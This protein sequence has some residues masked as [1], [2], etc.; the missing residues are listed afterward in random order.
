MSILKTLLRWTLGERPPTWSGRIALEGLHDTITIRREAHGVP[1]IDARHE[2]DAWVGLGFCHAQDRAF[3]LELLLRS[4]RGTLSEVIGQEGLPIDRL[5]RR[6]GFLRTG[7]EQLEVAD[8]QTQRQLEAYARGVS[9]GL[10]KG[11][12]K[13][14]PEFVL[15]GSQP[16]AWQAEDVQGLIVLLCF[17]LASNWDVELARLKILQEDGPDALQSLDPSYLDALPVCTPPGAP[18]H[19]V[20]D[21]LSEDLNAFQALHGVSGGSN[22]WAIA[23]ERTCTGGPILAADPHLPPTAP[24]PVYLARIRT[25]TFQ[26]V[27]M[28]FVGIPSMGWG[29]NLH[30]AWGI[31][32]AHADNTDLF[33]ERVGSDGRSVLQDTHYQPCPTRREVISVKGADD[34]VEEVLI[35]PRGPL[36]GA[37]FEGCPDGISISGTWLAKRPYNGILGI[38]RARTPEEAKAFFE[39][40]SASSVNLVYASA[41][42]HVGW[43][44][45]VEIPVRRQG[46]G[47]LPTPGWGPDAG[48]EDTVISPS[49]LPG[50]EDP[51]AG[52]VASANNKPVADDACPHF[53]GTDWLDGYR[54]ARICEVLAQKDDW[55][56]DTT[57]ALQI[58]VLSVPWRQV[59]ARVLALNAHTPDATLALTQLARWDGHLKPESVGASIFVLFM[60][61]MSARVVNAK[62]PRAAAWAMG[63]GFN[64]LLPHNLLITRRTSHLVKL[65]TETPERRDYFEGGWDQEMLNALSA[66]V[67][68][69]KDTHGRDVETWQWGQVR[70]L[71]LLH[72]FGEKRPLDRVFNSPP[73][74]FG[75]DATTVLQGALELRHPTKNPVGVPAGRIVVD[76]KNWERSRFVILGGQSGN[77]LSKHYLDQVEPWQQGDGFE[78]DLRTQAVLA[79]TCHTLELVEEK[80]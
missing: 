54:Q 71:R 5:S 57:M 40:G 13:R 80:A 51:P 3:Q 12:R 59:R 69:L 23:K 63:Q 48:W 32:A 4:V 43:Q 41:D 34:I 2:D 6:V 67:S 77:P 24:G 38:H 17:A 65:M 66:V 36:I 31:T 53:L 50:V 37:A 52:F 11:S 42:G 75:S 46:S 79:S 78:L 27:G 26:T 33:L 9:Q 76:L 25:P 14:A 62:A 64:A 35:T 39:A 74:A 29:H 55:D 16:S 47:Q 70:P 58:D 20:V 15:L 72:P 7:R 61:E 44:L 45:A 18:A 68:T 22:A 73:I 19:Q 8:P 21:R 30:L 49:E 1:T 10:L 60:S 56:V 28:T